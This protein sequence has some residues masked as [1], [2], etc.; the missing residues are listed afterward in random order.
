[1]SPDMQHQGVQPR[2]PKAVIWTI[3]VVLVVG[4]IGLSY[5]LYQK[6]I[7][8]GNINAGQNVNASV[9]STENQNVATGN[10]N[11]ATAIDMT[12]WKTYH[13]SALKFSLR[14]PE[15]LLAPTG[16]DSGAANTT[17]QGLVA[18]SLIVDGTKAYFAPSYFYTADAGG[19][20]RHSTTPDSIAALNKAYY[21]EFAT[22]VVENDEQLTRFIQQKYGS[23]C[24]I[25]GKGE[26]STAG[27]YDVTL[28]GDGQDL[29]TTKC[30]VNY[31]AKVKYSA[32]STHAVAWNV[33][34]DCTLTSRM[35]AAY[36]AECNAIAE[37][38]A[39][40]R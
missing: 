14:A 20:R 15:Q 12:T 29:A 1:M 3:L 31:V 11:V 19:C 5:Y 39:F 10:A 33:G 9:N 32:V 13:T 36:F 27:E 21:W 17:T 34:Q 4:A 6:D 22:A 35:D 24:S 8:S 23:G 25:G 26:T 2:V 37:S 40:T 7:E 16:C 30:P 28:A 38:F 18:Y